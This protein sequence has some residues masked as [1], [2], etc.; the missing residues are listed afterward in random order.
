MR[1][2]I[3]IVCIIILCANQAHS[4]VPGDVANFMEGFVVGVGVCI[5]NKAFILA[6]INYIS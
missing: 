5:I 4:I 6:K 3:S 1:T 2:I